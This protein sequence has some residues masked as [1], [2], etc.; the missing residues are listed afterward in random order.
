ME[1][2]FEG[3]KKLAIIGTGCNL[4]CVDISLINKLGR[5]NPKESIKITGADN[6]RINTN[7]KKKFRNKNVWDILYY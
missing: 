2:E 1:V 6:K 5:I 4:S 3:T 7:R